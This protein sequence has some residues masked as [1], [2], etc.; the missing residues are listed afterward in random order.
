M[1]SSRIIYCLASA[2][3]LDFTRRTVYA[4]SSQLISVVN[5]VCLWPDNY[6]KDL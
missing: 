1:N 2:R 3:R 4:V 6:S 5:L